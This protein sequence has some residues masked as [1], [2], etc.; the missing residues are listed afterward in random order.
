[1]YGTPPATPRGINESKINI[2][3]ERVKQRAIILLSELS[4]FIEFSM[5]EERPNINLE[6]VY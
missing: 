6:A 3:M 5:S 2:A 4:F 1:M